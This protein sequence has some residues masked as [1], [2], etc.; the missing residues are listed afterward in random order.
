[1]INETRVLVCY[2][3]P[4]R[5]YQNYLGKEV[6]DVES[7]V[8][9]SESEFSKLITTIE[10]ALKMHFIEVNSIALGSNVKIN[11][12]NILSYSPDII[13]NCVESIDGKSNFESYNAGLFDILEIPYTG[14]NLACLGN[15]LNKSRTKLIL[16]SY[17]INTPNFLTVT[18]CNIPKENDINIKYPVIVKLLNEDASIGISENSVISDY[19]TLKQRLI[20]LFDLF[21]QDI[22][23]E[24]YIEGRELNVAIL[25]NQVL[26]ISEIIFDGLPENLPRIV[27]YEAKW[28][29]NSTYFKHTKPICPAK[30]DDKI[31][32]KLEKIAIESF[33]AMECRDYA[34]IDIRLDK[35]GIPYVIEVN[36]NPDISPDSGFV[37]SAATAGYSYDKLLYTIIMLALKRIK[38]DTQVTV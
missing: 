25:G 29:E 27:T 19:R 32:S 31:K 5:Y 24:E 18:Y 12:Q 30:L 11:V 35:K 37:R 10:Q 1:M 34:R 23:I 7:N 2:N 4:V 17:G 22:I 36:P 6:N 3:E 8:D 33:N 21:K 28:S 38:H 14:N 15:C 20:Y 13:L 9:L 16:K 26:P